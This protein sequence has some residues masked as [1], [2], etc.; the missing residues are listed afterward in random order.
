[1]RLPDAKLVTQ[2]APW[3]CCKCRKHYPAS[4]SAVNVTCQGTVDEPWS[5]PG[6]RIDVG[7]RMCWSCW[8]HGLSE[9][10]QRDKIQVRFEAAYSAWTDAWAEGLRF[11]CEEDSDPKLDELAEDVAE[12]GFRKWALDRPYLVPQGIRAEWEAQAKDERE[13]ARVAG[14]TEDKL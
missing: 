9:I 8:F 6:M 13:A 11:A 4:E 5:R 1:M 2:V 12:D 10:V 3:D 14:V 7:I